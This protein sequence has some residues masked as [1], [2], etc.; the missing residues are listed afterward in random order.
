MDRGLCFG[1]DELLAGVP[2][3]TDL[4]EAILLLRTNSSFTS[5]YICKRDSGPMIG[6]VWH[7]VYWKYSQVPGIRLKVLLF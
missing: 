3:A 1:R 4:V 5:P 2:T 6:D 7:K